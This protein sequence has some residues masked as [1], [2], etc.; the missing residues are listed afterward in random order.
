[1]TFPTSIYSDDLATLIAD[2]GESTTWTDAQLSGSPFTLTAIITD[3]PITPIPETRG[4]PPLNATT[5]LYAKAD[6]PSSYDLTRARITWDGDDYRP[7]R[8]VDDTETLTLEC[9]K[10]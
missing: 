8:H 10:L 9:Q 2:F 1:M 4:R 5:F 6:L 7:V 3:G